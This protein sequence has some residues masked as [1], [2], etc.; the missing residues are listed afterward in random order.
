MGV[1]SPVSGVA[2]AVRIQR[3]S[4]VALSAAEAHGKRLDATGRGRVVREE[5]PLSTT[6][7]DLNALYDGHV[8]GAKVQKSATKALH[9]VMQFPADLVDGDDAELMLAHARTFA[10]E[11]FGT[12]AIFADR[13]DRDEKSRHVVDLFI[14]PKYEK[15]TKRQVQTAISTSRD[16]KAL[17]ARYDRA[18][19]LRGQGQALQDA[20]YE[21]LRDRLR[22][23]VKR[24][25]PKKQ[26][27]SDWKSAEELEADRLKR[28]MQKL[29]EER[30][31]VQ[32][33]MEELNSK[34]IQIE[35]RR[36]SL[37]WSIESFKDEQKEFIKKRKE[38]TDLVKSARIAAKSL[39]EIF[40]YDFLKSFQLLRDVARKA[41]REIGWLNNDDRF[42]EKSKLSEEE[43]NEL[44][45]A[46]E[47]IIHLSN[48]LDNESGNEY[49]YD[50]DS[51]VK[52]S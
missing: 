51:S 39:T 28:E 33:K 47:T 21:Y 50:D 11:I 9:M 40:P 41:F 25:E 43:I 44:I 30:K 32:D 42:T 24:G 7:L 15:K 26:P 8:E 16:L 1:G 20:W 35:R 3:L 13:V 45:K 5:K 23:E 48:I 6:G 12:S 52:L 2:G 17:A 49:Y 38:L 4:G 27:G 19:T 29:E 18:P 37:E 46:S 31:A 22:L 14:A 36:I 10:E 34:S